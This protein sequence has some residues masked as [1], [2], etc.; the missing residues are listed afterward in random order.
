[1]CVCCHCQEDWDFLQLQVA[2]LYNSE[3]SGIPLHM[4][5]LLTLQPFNLPYREIMIIPWTFNFVCFVVRTIYE[6][7]IPMKYLLTLVIFNIIWNPLIQVSTIMFI[8]VKS[9]KFIAHEIKLFYS[10]SACRKYW[11]V[12]FLHFFCIHFVFCSTYSKTWLFVMGI[13]SIF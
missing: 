4:Q 11:S 9:R 8:V 3:T 13:L 7:K 2:L 12:F 10:T 6:F 1:M 5:V